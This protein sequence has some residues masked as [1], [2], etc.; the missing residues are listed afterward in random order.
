MKKKGGILAAMLTP[1][2]RNGEVSLAGVAPLVD[3]ILSQGVDG[4]Y[5]SGSSGESVLQ[6]QEERAAL[7]TELAGYAKGKCTLVAHVGSASTREATALAEVAGTNG[8][9][10]VSAV[11]PFYFKHNFD[12]IK[13]YYLAIAEAAELPVI[14][15][16]IPALSGIDIGTEQLLV[17]LKDE[18]IAGVK[19][20]DTNL[21][22]YA[23]LRKAAPGKA[24][25]FGTDQMFISAAASGTDGG[26]G[27]TYNLIGD[28]FVGIRDAI[29]SGDIEKARALQAKV[30]GLVEILFETG[31]LP[32]L[33]YV[34]NSLGVPVGP[35]RRPF[36]PPSTESLGKLDR[37]VEENIKR[38]LDRHQI[39]ADAA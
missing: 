36:S 24:F 23:Q 2:D 27:S 26:I 16:N 30:N 19:Y 38:D 4:L 29:A 11:P 1:F 31:V 35:C 22:Q 8:Y 6:S 21:F 14:I 28:A 17:L 5:A 32:G 33:K 3:F 15:Y 37:W 7:L 10:A 13:N 20:T 34:L 25:Y 9:D 12:D 39:A 18:R